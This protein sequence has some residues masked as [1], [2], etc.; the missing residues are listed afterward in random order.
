MD[1]SFYSFCCKKS[2]TKPCDPVLCFDFKP[3]QVRVFF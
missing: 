1:I 3:K 2:F